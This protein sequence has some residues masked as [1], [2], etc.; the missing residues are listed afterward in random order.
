VKVLI[1]GGTKFL[2]RAIVDAALGRGHAVT[3][4]NR[5]VTN[6]DLYPG[7]ETVHGDRRAGGISALSGRSFDAV[8]DVA[9]MTPDDVQPAVDALKGAVG[10]YVFVSTVSVYADHSGPQVEGQDVLEL[11]DGLDP[12]AAYGA[13]KAAAEKRVVTAY[14]DNAFIVRPGLIVG[15][16]DA[17][18]R[19][20]YWPRRIAR[21]GRV[22]APPEQH[23]TQ[24]IDVRDLAR[25]IVHGVEGGLS[26]TCNATG[27]PGTIGELIDACLATVTQT[28]CE[29]EW[30][31]ND[32]LLQAGLSPWMGLP[33]WIAAPEWQGANQVVI[34][35]A[36]SAG[37]EFRPL[38]ETVRD[39]LA[40]DLAR[41]GPPPGQEGLSVSREAELLE[42]IFDG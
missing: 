35:R 41:G 40:W 23:P 26:G 14:G 24:F 21:G 9:A 33:L 32:R 22:L 15:P 37:L 10:R 5:G 34:D 25:W 17:T 20:A 31:S 36:L 19:F 18:D 39:T 2:G 28:A 6:P 1:L 4:F 42:S 3:L 38:T 29:I 13:E 8:V 11:R 30:T 27:R 12:G 7:L 16:H